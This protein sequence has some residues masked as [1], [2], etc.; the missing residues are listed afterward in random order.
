LTVADYAQ[1]FQVHSVRLAEA[2]FAICN[3]CARQVR[4]RSVGLSKNK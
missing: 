2:S 4:A 1:I 3:A